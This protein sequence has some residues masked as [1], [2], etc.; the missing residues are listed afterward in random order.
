[1]ALP[2]V[3]ERGTAQIPENLV[4]ST[5]RCA[6]DALDGFFP[7]GFDP[8]ET[9]LERLFASDSSLR[10]DHFQ[11]GGWIVQSREKGSL[12]VRQRSTTLATTQVLLQINNSESIKGTAYVLLFETKKG[13]VELLGGAPAS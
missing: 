3:L 6:K 8:S 4:R 9:D 13:K 10:I 11:I 7:P 2:E 12:P 5:L 1:M